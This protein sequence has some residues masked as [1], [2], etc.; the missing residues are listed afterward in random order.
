MMPPGARRGDGGQ[1][2]GRD[3]CRG[4]VLGVVNARCGGSGM[5]SGGVGEHNQGGRRWRMCA[6]GVR[7]SG[8]RRHG[9]IRM[10]MALLPRMFR[11]HVLVG[12][13]TRLFP[14]TTIK[15]LK[16]SSA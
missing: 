6:R 12:T 11:M 15:C 16:E 14:L 4:I 10:L 2:L 8:Q 1:Q 5:S 9:W 3:G 13:Q 7:N